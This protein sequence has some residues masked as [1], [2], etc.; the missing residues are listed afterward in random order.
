MC[1]LP[2]QANFAVENKAI[3]T[4]KML[5]YLTNY[6]WLLLDADFAGKGW[7]W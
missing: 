5:L 4:I 3:K 2:I 1:H 6:A 7:G